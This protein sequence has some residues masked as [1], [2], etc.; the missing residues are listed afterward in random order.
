MTSKRE[1]PG[2]VPGASE[3]TISERVSNQK[4]IPEVDPSR[5]RLLHESFEGFRLDVK[6]FDVYDHENYTC[7]GSRTFSGSIRLLTNFK[8]L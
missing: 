6:S 3:S 4:F 7:K 5:F 2:G 8:S 1:N